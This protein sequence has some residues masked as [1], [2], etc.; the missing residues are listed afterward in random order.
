MKHTFVAAVVLLLATPIALAEPDAEPAATSDEALATFKRALEL[1]S[2]GD[3]YSSIELLNSLLIAEPSLYRA[4]LELAV[5]YYRAAEFS[6]AR[7][8]AEE[9]LNSPDV[10]EDVKQTVAI[11]LD[12]INSLQE[13]DSARRHSFSGNVKAGIGY[14]DNVN[15]GPVS[16]VIDIGGLEF[17]LVDE[18]K[19]RSDQFATYSA[20]ISHSY[21]MPGTVN[22]GE[23]PA[24]SL[25][26]SSLSA[27]RREYDDEHKY[28]VDV[29]SASTGMALLSRSSWRAKLNLQADNI[30]LEDDALAVYYSLN[31]TWTYTGAHNNEY[32]LRGQVLYRDYRMAADAGREGVRSTLAFDYSHRLKDVWVV[33]TGASLARQ[34]ARDEF[35]K[36]DIYELYVS[37]LRDLWEGGSGFVSVSYRDTD[38][39][40]LEPLF[41]VG[42]E[43][44]QTRYLAGVV[45]DFSIGDVKG[46]QAG[47]RYVYT[48]N[49]ANIGIY[50]YDRSEVTADVAKRF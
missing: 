2:S 7:Q 27:Y 10:D 11:F 37:V 23:R 9:V 32:T 20:S 17:T 29:I 22:V 45:H 6:R 50:Q 12:Q 43:E 39:D 44:K 14:D 1:R 33:Q 13:A 38:Y 24:F 31:P 48:D 47:L 30:R 8:M 4:R 34:N 46:F 42:R 5:A 19:P 25:W 40:G 28:T 3:I 36:Q 21:R 49:K 35:E 41:G 18:S 26:Q 16:D 15:V